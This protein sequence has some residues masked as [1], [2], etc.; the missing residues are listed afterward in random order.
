MNG[1]GPFRAQQPAERRAAA[2]RPEPAA[3]PAPEAAHSPAAKPVQHRAATQR[4]VKEEKPRKRPIVPIVI[5][6]VLIVA[7]VVGWSFWS[8]MFGGLGAA[9]DK[10]KYQAVF[11]ANGQVYFGKLEVTSPEYVKLT[12]VYYLQTPET[13]TEDDAK[14]PQKSTSEQDMQLIKL[15]NELHGPEDEMIISR[16]QVLFYENLKADGKVSQSIEQSQ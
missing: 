1:G 10:S 6:T 9:I 2:S 14:D 16:D 3:R 7:A 8:N 15:G 12:S 5:V 11:L 13:K 4:V